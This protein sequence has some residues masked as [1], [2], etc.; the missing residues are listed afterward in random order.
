MF[1]YA[2]KCM[3]RSGKRYKEEEDVVHN[4]IFWFID[5]LKK[6]KC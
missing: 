3:G 1:K 4:V 5:G 6:L 2:M